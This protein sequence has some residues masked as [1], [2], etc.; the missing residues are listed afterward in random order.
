MR[1]LNRA[2]QGLQGLQEVEGVSARMHAHVCTRVRV[3]VHASTCMRIHAHNH[4][5]LG[6]SHDLL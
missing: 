4:G 6:A 3:C 5:P 1:A 2:L